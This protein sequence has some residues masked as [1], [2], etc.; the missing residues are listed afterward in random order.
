[1]RLRIITDEGTSAIVI[2]GREASEVFDAF[3]AWQNT[4][5][6]SLK[7]VQAWDVVIQTANDY[8]E[9]DG[10]EGEL[11]IDVVMA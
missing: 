11:V 6:R 2:E 1:M 3:R 5:P 4:V 9:S 7:E 10:S 8:M